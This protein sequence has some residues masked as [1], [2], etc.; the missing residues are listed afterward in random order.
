MRKTISIIYSTLPE[1]GISC[2]SENIMC[3]YISVNTQWQ[4]N[5]V[6]KLIPAHTFSNIN[7]WYIKSIKQ[8]QMRLLHVKWVPCHH[9]MACPQVCRWRRRPPDMEGSCKYI[10]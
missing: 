3:M 7:Y 10:E 9:S 5:L 4:H 6:V 2:N 1:N 8:M